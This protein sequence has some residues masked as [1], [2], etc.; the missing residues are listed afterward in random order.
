MLNATRSAGPDTVGQGQTVYDRATNMAS[1]RRRKEAV[2]AHH[3]RAM[4]GRLVLAHAAKHTPAA[5]ADRLGQAVVANHTLDVQRF[6]FDQTM[7]SDHAM[8]E[9][10]QEVLAL[11][12]DGL[13]LAGDTHARLV[14]VGAALLLASQPALQARQPLLRSV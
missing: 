3:D 5:V 1:L 11:A 2:D 4:P 13:A 9:L 7:L 10:L 8:T 12:S 6:E 14:A